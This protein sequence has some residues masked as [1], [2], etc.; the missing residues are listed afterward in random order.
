M[1]GTS[2][3]TLVKLRSAGDS[4]TMQV[5][6]CAKMTIGTYPEISFIGSDGA[7]Q[8]EIRVPE[9]SANRQLER[10]GM[11]YPDCAGKVMTFARDPN[12]TDPAKPFWSITLAAG[13]KVIDTITQ[14]GEK[15]VAQI[16]QSAVSTDDA[17]LSRIFGI[18]EACFQ[19]AY[20][21][22]KALNEKMGVPVTLEGLSALTAQCMIPFDRGR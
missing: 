10:L 20:K 1:P 21:M 2:E 6:T 5:E 22:A 16:A 9:K 14:T 3:A 18:Q 11:S 7:R 4:L 15:A 12:R 19:H 17:R 13:Q 8:V